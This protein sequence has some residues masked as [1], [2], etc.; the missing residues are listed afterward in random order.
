MVSAGVLTR[1]YPE[2]FDRLGMPA[3]QLLTRLAGMAAESVK[4]EKSRLMLHVAELRLGLCRGN[5]VSS[6]G[7]LQVLAR[8]GGRGFLRLATVRPTAEPS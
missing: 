6:R 3:M 5:R 4:L 2:T 1:L 8:V 7:G